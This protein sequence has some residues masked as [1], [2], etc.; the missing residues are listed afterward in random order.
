MGDM[1]ET[2]LYIIQSE[3]IS[4]AT[5][6]N[7]TTKQE[8]TE[9]VSE[10][11]EETIDLSVPPSY[12]MS[13]S[14]EN[15]D[16]MGFLSRP[17]EIHTQT[18]TEGTALDPTTHHFLPWHLFLNRS[19]IKNKIENYFLLRANLH[20]K[21]IVNASP[22]YY[23]AA[24]LTYAPETRMEAAVVGGTGS[25]AYN[26]GYSQRPHINIFPQSNQGGELVLPFIWP[27]EWVD[28]T[29]AA[30]VQALG[31]C[32][33][34]SFGDLL[35]ANGVTGQAITIQVFAWLENVQLSGPTAEAA[36]QAGNV[37]DEYDEGPL[38]KPASAIARSTGMLSNLPLVGNF[39][40]ATSYAAG[41]VAGIAKLFGYTNVP[42]IDDLHGFRNMPLPHLAT[43]D[44]GV[45]SE[46]LTLDAKNELSTDPR[47]CGVDA[48][49]ELLM[50]YFCGRESF[51]FDATWTTAQA[52]GYEILGLG[53]SPEVKRVISGTNEDFVHKSPMG[54][55]ATMF[56]YWRGDIKV[57]IKV[58]CSQY[59]RGRLLFTWDP[60]GAN[61][62]ADGDKLYNKIVDISENTD[63]CFTIPYIQPT[64]YRQT[65]GSISIFEGWKANG[66]GINMPEV[67]CNGAVGLF[68]NNV[69]TAPVATADVKIL[70]YMSAG[71][72]FELAAP[73]DILPQWS[74][75]QVQSEDVA[76][77]GDSDKTELAIGNIKTMT[78]D[79]INLVYQG[80]SI[81]SL[82]TLYRRNGPYRLSYDAPSF[83]ASNLMQLFVNT[84][85]RR[86]LY[87]GFDP[88]GVDLATGLT[89]ATSHPYNWVSWTPM[90]WFD[91]CFVGVKGS[92]RWTANMEYGNS[93]HFISAN[94][95]SLSLVASSYNFASSA[96]NTADNVK[97]RVVV[98]QGFGNVAGVSASNTSVMPTLDVTFPFYS[99][100]KFIEAT[101]KS[102]TLG[103]GSVGSDKDSIHFNMVTRPNYNGDGKSIMVMFGV[104]AGSDYTP[105]FF[106]NVP[107]MILYN[108]VPA[109]P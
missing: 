7:A 80:E 69:L 30:D 107:T 83:S 13:L 1:L 97:R 16:L 4:D 63:V 104:S 43:C 90:T 61:A 89:V 50:E 26:V 38:S 12:L 14:D 98:H 66:V 81:K 60:Y 64:A 67:Y 9:F 24:L 102:R 77:Y 19:T 85:S 68:V 91:Q 56:S 101:P 92:V 31:R 25:T 53:V 39:F 41:K 22:F 51:V 34:S 55:A 84:M 20:L 79:N 87:P 54:H 6:A 17:Y 74:P 28:I 99:Q 44:I 106:L 11:T 45:P 88:N 76:V 75:Y 52:T 65:H 42:V 71:P 48:N 94:R 58:V 2:D 100:Y 32:R 18:W 27:E 33:F 10:T 109:A 103:L 15:A 62:T 36:L 95:G 96:Q 49:D 93:A 21:V 37:E 105:V 5:G 82:R 78:D 3:L 86:P 40:T 72:N 29:S 47:I 46:K 108:T 8:V 57:R 70:V 35:N 23:G 59:H 73:R